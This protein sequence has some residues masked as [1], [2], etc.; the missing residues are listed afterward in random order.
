MRLKPAHTFLRPLLML[1][2]MVSYFA[3]GDEQVTQLI[4]LYEPRPVL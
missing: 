3:L 4:A 2:I 1:L